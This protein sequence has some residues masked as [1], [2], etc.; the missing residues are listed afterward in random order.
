MTRGGVIAIGNFDGVHRGHQSMIATLRKRA[1]EI[2]GPAVVVTFDPPPIEVLRRD[3]AP[4]RLMTLERKSHFLKDCGADAVVALRTEERLLELGAEEFFSSVLLGDL[5]IRGLVEGPNFR[6]GRGRE[7]DIALLKT[8]CE[9]SSVPLTV[10]RPVETAG[11]M[12]SSSL[13]RELV[14]AGELRR[15][16]TLLGRPHEAVGVVERGAGRGADLGFPTANLT[17]I[18]TLLPPDGVYAG[19]TIL[20]ENAYAVAVHLGPNRTFRETTRNFE[21][22]LLDF[23][24]DLYGRTLCVELIDRVRESN[25]FRSPEALVSQMTLDCERIRTLVAESSQGD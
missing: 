4:P 13:I 20:D 15:A 17:G 24:G 16:A 21:A 23:A 2:G 6:F 12:V 8:L 10:I 22:H 9:R 25:H 7:G 5:G 11:E 18:A 3:V 19:R 14:A 1:A